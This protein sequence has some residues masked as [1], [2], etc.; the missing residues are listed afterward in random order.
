VRKIHAAFF[1][2]FISCMVHAQSSSIWFS[3][4]APLRIKNWEWHQDAGYRTI[5]SSARAT[6]WFYR[7]GVR[8]YFSEHW[9]A[10]G[11]YALFSSRVENDRPAFGAENRIWE[12]LVRQ[13]QWRKLRWVQRLRIEHRWFDATTKTPYFSAHRFRYRTAFVRALTPQL[14]LQVYDEIMV[15]SQQGQ[16]LFNQNRTGFFLH[17]KSS[18]KQVFNLGYTYLHQP[19]ANTHLFLLGY[20]HNMVR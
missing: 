4:Q 13:D 12:E 5:G 14:D 20:Q 8:R 3:A 11:G 2:L 16:W 19:L 9:N 15:Q 7:T 18:Q 10:A 1:L 6:L 17:I